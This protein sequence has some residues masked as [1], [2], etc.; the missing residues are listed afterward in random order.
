[1]RRF[2]VLA[3]VSFALVV[4]VQGAAR[5]QSS[6]QTGAQMAAK[7]V[8]PAAATAAPTVEQILDRY[9]KAIGGREAWQKFT[10][11]VSMGTIEVPSMN[12][13]G[14]VMIHE[15]APDK[16]LDS[17]VINGASFR[18][19]F[20]GTLGWTDDP[21]DGLRE[22][23]GA[24]LAE[25]R[26]DA[27]F[28]HPLDLRR[29]YAKLTVSGKEKIGGRDTYVVEATV[30]EGSEPTKMYFDSESG[31]LLRVVK[32]NHGADGVTQFREDFEDY[33]DV[34]GIK[35]PF[36]SHQTNGDTTYTMT[37]SE[38]RHN[39]ELNDSEFAKPAVQ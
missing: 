9:V 28:F 32:Q 33:R 2:F 11:R 38:V 10:S 6:S 1:M 18:Q 13:S 20:D 29:L 14:V 4:T 8:T 12:L 25:A 17:V 19:G 15:K 34:D 36:T 21:Q 27:D 5:G 7:P 24:E 37:I 3:S 35:V 26:R 31:L 39:V 16:L 23:T 30:P 22:Q